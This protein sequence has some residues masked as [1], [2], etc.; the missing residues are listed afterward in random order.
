MTHVFIQ[1]HLLSSHVVLTLTGMFPLKKYFY[2]I[3]VVPIFPPWPTSAQPTPDD[4]HSNIFADS[5]PRVRKV[6]GKVN[7]DCIKRKSFRTAKEAII[8]MKREP[9]I[10]ENVFDL[11]TLDRSLIS[12]TDKRACVIQLPGIQRIQ[13]K[14]IVSSSDFCSFF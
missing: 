6:K 9:T 3:I 12:K 2:S 4:P 11:G 10:W 5:S 8:R 1:Q 7:R 14:R 13:I